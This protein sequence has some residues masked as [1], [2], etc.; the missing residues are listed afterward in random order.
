VRSP[1]LVLTRV[2]LSDILII[3]KAQ[4]SDYGGSVR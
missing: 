1:L 4:H 2:I 3:S